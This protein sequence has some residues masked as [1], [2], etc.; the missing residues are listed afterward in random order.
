MQVD[1]RSR[2]VLGHAIEARCSCETEIRMSRMPK[3]PSAWHDLPADGNARRRSSSPPMP[4]QWP[5]I[6][7]CLNLC[8][9][10]TNLVEKAGP[11]AMSDHQRT[12]AEGESQEPRGTRRETR[13]AAIEDL[14][15]DECRLILGDRTGPGDERTRLPVHGDR[16]RDLLRHGGENF[17]RSGF[18]NQ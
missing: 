2:N 6:R 7:L 1:R 14:R 15:K 17:W 5:G 18:R 10:V 12:A 16:V 8:V 13:G 4:H 9:L 3:S 11:A